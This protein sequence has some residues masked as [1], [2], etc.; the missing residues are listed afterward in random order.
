M[1]LLFLLGL[2]PQ[3]RRLR[4]KVRSQWL[5]LVNFYKPKERLAG[6]LPILPYTLGSS[7]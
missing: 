3:F 5:T 1:E 2:L 6:A 4:K 7:Y